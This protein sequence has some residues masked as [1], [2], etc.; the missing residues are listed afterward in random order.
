[1]NEG[2]KTHCRICSM[3]DLLQVIHHQGFLP[4]FHQD[5]LPSLED[6][7]DPSVWFTDREGPWE[8]KGKLASSKQCIYAKLAEGGT[9]FVSPDLYPSLIRIRRNGYDFEGMWE[10]GLLSRTAGNIMNSVLQDGPTQA[11]HI[12]RKLG[13]PKDFDRELIHLQM[14]TFLVH[15]DFVYDIDRHG[16]PYGWG[17]ALLDTPEHLF[18]EAFVGLSDRMTEET[19]LDTLCRRIGNDSEDLRQLLSGSKKRKRKS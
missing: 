13:N 14:L 4:F 7:I 12:R 18:G 6:M 11:R 10:D 1:M 9:V 19:A 5:A 8:W 15:A 17:N 16:H 2:Y 3:E